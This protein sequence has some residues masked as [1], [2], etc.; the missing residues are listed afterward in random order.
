M[1]GTA[2]FLISSSTLAASSRSPP[3][4]D[5]AAL[6]AQQAPL[7]QQYSDDP[8][9][10]LVTLSSTSTLE[11]G[12]GVA[13][14]LSVGKALKKAGLH[15]MAGGTD[16]EQLCAPSPAIHRLRRVRL[17]LTSLDSCSGDMLL[18]SLVA[19]TGVTLKAVATSLDIPLRK[20]SITAEGDLDFRSVLLL[21]SGSPSSSG[22]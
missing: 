10:A 19:C 9:S 17:E 15:A 8:A 3:A 5:K 2:P 6:Q 13:C 12:G 16:A 21:L 14:S 4:M 11:E 22:S 20:G 1:R 18:E 7:K